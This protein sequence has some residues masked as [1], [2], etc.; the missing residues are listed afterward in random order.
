[1]KIPELRSGPG[2]QM[3]HA[4]GPD[5]GLVCQEVGVEAITCEYKS[6]DPSRL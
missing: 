2:R 1:M 5:A 6:S 3:R 4:G